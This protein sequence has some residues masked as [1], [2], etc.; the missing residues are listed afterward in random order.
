MSGE[1]DDMSEVL[2]AK[3]GTR[4]YP[5]HDQTFPVLTAAEIDRIRRFGE[6][7]HYADGERL[8]E[9]GKIGPGMFVILSGH[10]CVTQRDGLG[11]V[12]PVADHGP[13][14]F[15]AEI[16]QLSGRVALVDGT[17]EG[18][19]EALLIAPDRLRALL[20]ADADLGEILTEAMRVL[21]FQ[22]DEKHLNVTVDCPDAVALRADRRA[23]KQIALNLLS[24][25]VKFT[26]EGGRVTLSARVEA[27]SVSVSIRDTGIGIPPEQIKQL[28][29]PFVQVANQFTKQHR[30]SGLGLAIARSLIELHG[31]RMTIV[32][33]P[34]EGTTVTFTLPMAG[35]ET[36]PSNP[37]FSI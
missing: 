14:E 28:G 15:S 29:R 23:L 30:G 8:F 25:A 4:V 35:P 37:A 11:H 1:S 5:R 13:G 12:S 26:P 17:A 10:V 27:A 36:G 9:T 32:S 6:V 3:P 21:S 20:V 19:V 22:A 18:E 33:T 2:D 16:A 31:G 34:G 24:N 7:K